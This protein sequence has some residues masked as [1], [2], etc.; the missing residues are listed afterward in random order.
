[1]TAPTPTPAIVVTTTAHR[2][3]LGERHA[4]LHV[5]GAEVSRWCQTR[6]GTILVR[7]RPDSGQLW[8][9][10]PLGA[11]QEVIDAFDAADRRGA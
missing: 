9:V 4:V 6:D 11:P 5:D 3:Y 10:P 8:R 7:G 2:D 1:M